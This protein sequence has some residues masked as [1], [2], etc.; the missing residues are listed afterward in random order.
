MKTILV[1]VAL[2]TTLGAQA[3]VVDQFKCE[4]SLI[5]PDGK[6][7]FSTESEFEIARHPMNW[8]PRPDVVITSGHARISTY[9]KELK[10]GVNFSLSYSHA[11]EIDSNGVAI[12]GAQNLCLA[13]GYST[14]D[15]GVATA[16]RGQVGVDPFDPQS[17]YTPVE[18][19]MGYPLFDE[20]ALSTKPMEAGS[21]GKFV[22]DCKYKGTLD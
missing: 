4:M 9:I 14:G 15:G 3:A 19:V 2:L 11:L 18:V 20:S 12:R 16:C 10:M 13:P 17:I 7:A 21:Y 22:I 5:R 8:S 6:T 1:L